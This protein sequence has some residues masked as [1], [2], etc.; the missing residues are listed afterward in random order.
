MNSVDYGRTYV[1]NYFYCRTYSTELLYNSERDLL[2]IAKWPVKYYEDTS[3][4]CCKMLSERDG[5]ARL[6]CKFT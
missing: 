1:S 6:W 3:A 2:A 5:T 4:D